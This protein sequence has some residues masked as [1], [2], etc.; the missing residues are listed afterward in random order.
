MAPARLRERYRWIL[1]DEFQD[2]NH[3][4][5]ELLRLLAGEAANITVVGDDDQAIYRWR[6]AAAANLLAFRRLYSG[7]REVVLTEN[8]RSTQVI[9][10]A[11]SRLV[12]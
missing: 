4:Q 8:Y 2:T 12:S 7:C 10:D 5:L 6:G 11:A 1:V 9:L 3:A